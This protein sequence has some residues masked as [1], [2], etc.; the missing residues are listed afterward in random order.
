[1]HKN[2]NLEELIDV[3]GWKAL[4]N[5]FSIQNLVK[6]ELSNKEINFEDSKKDIELLKSLIQDEV[7]REDN[8]MGLFD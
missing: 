1:M 4:G 6:I 5:K 3:K 8:Q 2:L 7:E